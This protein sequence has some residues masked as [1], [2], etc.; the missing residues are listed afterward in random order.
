MNKLE[1]NK[2]NNRISSWFN[3]TFKGFGT[4]IIMQL[5]EQLSFSFKADK[6]GALTKLVLAALGFGAVTAV[7]YLIINILGALGIL[8]ANILPVPLFNI[9]LYLI[10]ILNTLSCIHRMTKSLYFSRDNQTLLTY[11]VNNGTIFLS[12][13]VVY[14]ILELVKNFLMLIP[15]LLAYG[16]AHQFP[17]YYYP[18]MLFV[19]LIVAMLPVSIA[20][21]VSIPYMFVLSFL[22][23]SQYLQSILTIA[24][25]ITGTVLLFVGLSKIPANLQIASKWSNIY[26]PNVLKVSQTIEKFVGPLREIPGIFFGY[27]GYILNSSPKSLAI[28]NSRSPIII[29]VIFGIIIVSNVISYLLARPLF[30]KM[31]TKPFEYRKKIIDHNYKI[32]MVKA[33]L[34]SKAF[35]PMLRYPIS[36]QDK[37]GIVNKLSK[38]LRVV[39]KE[40]KLFLLRKINTKR[41]LRFLNKYV[42]DL[43]FEEVDLKQITDFG[44][45]IQIRRGV[46]FLVLIKGVKGN[47][48]NCYDPY[49]LKAKN[50]KSNSFLSIFIKDILTDIRTP[51]TI[52]SHFLLFIITPLAIAL[53]NAIFRAINASFQGQSFSIAFN[54]LIIMLITLSSNVSMAS[55]YSREGSASYMLKA[56]PVNYKLTL[57]SKLMIRAF[58][59]VMSLLATCIIYH[60]YSP[61]VDLRTDL[62]FLTFTFAYLAHLVWSAELDFMNPQ[63][64]LYQEVGVNVNN[65]NEVV[66][67]V[68]TFIIAG[69]FMAI[70]Y[71]LITKE[72]SLSYI[73]L[74]L[75]SL[76]FLIVRIGLYMLKIIGYGTSRAERRNQ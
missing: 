45:V 42:N 63:D 31:A 3:K 14:Y 56:A 36:K 55:I 59:V 75:I 74:M 16:L 35:R 73:K 51:G 13:I 38:L 10:V 33:E 29:L 39:N 60:Y 47:V 40:E 44:Y 28:V 23:K 57:V 50:F 15:M 11:P 49:H 62:L 5:K 4:L 46:P 68:L 9:F 8:G 64:R 76:A 22:K 72:Q 65:P 18:W 53:L 52:V 54:I 25:L 19:F 12:K 27:R 71:F 61:I 26:Y 2:K 21:V 17:V 32:N 37:K 58:I 48:A 20:G 30:F 41:I 69:L 70:G 1:S 24:A 67:A 66:S 7:I 34:Y 43:K 6:K